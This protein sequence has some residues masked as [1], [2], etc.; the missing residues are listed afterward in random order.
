[1]FDPASTVGFN[2][3]PSTMIAGLDMYLQQPPNCFLNADLKN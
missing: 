1:M 2:F 3:G